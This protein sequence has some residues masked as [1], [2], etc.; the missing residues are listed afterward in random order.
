V[1]PGAQLVDVDLSDLDPSP[2]PF[3]LGVQV[4]AD[5]LLAVE[6]GTAVLRRFFEGPIGLR[7]LGLRTA[8]GYLARSARQM[9]MWVDA[10]AESLVVEVRIAPELGAPID[11][12]A[13]FEKA[14]RWG[15]AAQKFSW[16]PG[17][18]TARLTQD[19]ELFASR[20]AP[21]EYP[22]FREVAQEVSL[23]T[24]NRLLLRP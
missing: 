3:R 7:A 4:R 16:D 23:R 14:H 20:V 5:G 21:A 18:R 19:T 8:E 24:R 15:R 17:S 1:L 12:P 2:D 6:G 9:P 22:T 11:P 10:V 13:S